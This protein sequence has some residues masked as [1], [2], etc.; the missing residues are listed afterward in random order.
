MNARYTASSTGT[1]AMNL[2]VKC[3][4]GIL[5]GLL[6]SVATPATAEWSGGIEGGAVVRDGDNATRLRLKLSNNDRP[7]NH[8]IYADWYRT[9]NG[10][11][12]YEAGYIPRYWFDDRLYLF[13]E[14]RYRVDKPLDID[15]DI[16]LIAGAG[17]QLIATADRLLWAEAGAGQR[18]TEFG[19]QQGAGLTGDDDN[20]YTF[21][22]LRGGYTQIFAELIRFEL[23]A[24]ALQ[25]EDL[26]ESTAEIGLSVN[27]GGGA[28]KVSY[29]TRR[30]K[31]N[32]SPAVTDSDTVVSFDYGF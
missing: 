3:G 18:D 17:Y 31:I 13:G 20:S 21:A 7:L 6:L 15:R 25:G 28:V 14:A 30:L 19:S 5:F 24:D 27:A 9:D 1:V 22:L 12:S 11:N 16:L 4:S 32:E 29:R 8:T 10:D 2:L 26:S 23:K